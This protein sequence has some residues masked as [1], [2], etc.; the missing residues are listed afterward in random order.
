MQY[1]HTCIK[2]RSLRRHDNRG[3]TDEQHVSLTTSSIVHDEQAELVVFSDNHLRSVSM[4]DS[5]VIVRQQP[6]ATVDNV[7]FVC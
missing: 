6:T 7:S 3:I 5:P 1:T 4:G 2:K